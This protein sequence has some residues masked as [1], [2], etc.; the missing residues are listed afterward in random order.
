MAAAPVISVSS[1]YLTFNGN[2]Y[3]AGP[4]ATTQIG[5]GAND[6][7]TLAGW[8]D[9]SGQGN[10][11]DYQN[12]VYNG[13][14]SDAGFGL[15]GNVTANGL[16]LII[17]V[18]GISI[19]DTGITLA[20]GQSHNV[21]LTH[22]NGD[23]T[24]YVDGHAD[25]TVQ[26]GANSMPGPAHYPDSFVIGGDA[27]GENFTGSIG[28]VSVWN[29]A[30]TQSQIQALELTSPS[31]GETNL[32]AYYPLNDGSGTTAADLVNSAGNLTLSGNPTWGTNSTTTNEN[33][34][35]TLNPLNVSFADAGSDIFTTTLDVNHGTLSI[36]NVP[37]VSES[38]LGTTSS[39]LILTGT[40]AAIDAA[41]G[42]V[43]YTPTAGYA[44]TDTLS[45]VAQ[46][47]AIS[48]NTATVNINVLG[49]VATSFTIGNSSG[50][51]IGRLVV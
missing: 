26:I 2:G 19:V 12:I 3:A 6:G 24:L 8:V 41:L 45:V 25:Y 22:V 15:L 4:L 14:T 35:L 18:G 36:G 34:P 38:G 13:S 16:D 48:S 9:W 39:P 29:A 33:A 51:H 31:G 11:G 20:A 40:L 42:G 47:G 43:V 44:G 5:N 32:A 50:S 28:E 37:G 17:L 21:A 1:P 10:I 30:L 46:D 49:P 23:F 7:V 27:G